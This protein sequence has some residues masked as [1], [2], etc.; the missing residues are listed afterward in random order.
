MELYLHIPF[1]VKKC[2]YCDFLS[3]PASVKEQNAYCEALLHELTEVQPLPESTVSSIF[4]GGGTPT[5]IDSEWIICFLE[6]IRN[7]F[8]VEENAEITI[9][10]NPGTLDERKLHDYR[11]AGV[12]RLSIGLQSADDRELGLLGRIHTYEEFLE[13]YR[14]AREAGFENI[15]VDLMMAI[16]GQDMESLMKTL[17][18]TLSLRPEHLSLY[19]L[20]VEPGTPFAERELNLPKE[21][22]ERRMY[23]E[24]VRYLEDWGYIQ[25]E[26]SN[27]AVPGRECRH[28]VGYWQR[29][30]YRG[31]GLGAASL[32]EEERFSNTSEMQEYLRECKR[33]EL[34]MRNREKLNRQAQMEEFMFL[35]LRMRRGV[36][37]K[38]FEE[39]FG[40]SLEEIYGKVIARYCGLGL[41]EETKE[42]VFL[43]FQGISVSNVIMS[44]FLL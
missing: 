10:A 20:I 42:R 31:F 30:P 41:M 14:K 11:R 19:S 4:I 8:S 32:I 37:K 15:N 28:N 34:L 9:E 5:V 40:C 6:R 44:D 13:N 36:E 17:S 21:E 16:P 12:N 39:T 38:K 43:T 24:A 23:E 2:D 3:G 29:T 35:G 22:E 18:R 25:Y 33:P 27:F 1:C 26:I 7:R